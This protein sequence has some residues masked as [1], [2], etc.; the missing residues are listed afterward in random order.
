MELNLLKTD[1]FGR[2]FIYLDSVDST[3]SYLKRENNLPDGTVVM[4]NNQYAGRG[5]R[6]RTWVQKDSGS[7]AISLL[8]HNADIEDMGTLPLLCGLAAAKAMDGR[9]KWP[10]DVVIG[11]KKVCGVLCESLILG[12]KIN[13]VCGFGVNL[14][15]DRESFIKED[16]PYASSILAQT[17]KTFT[18]TEIC[19]LILNELE[20]LWKEYKLNGISD[21]IS[22]YSENCVTL[23]KTVKVTVDGKETVCKAVGVNNNGSLNCEYNDEIFSVHSGEASVRGL[24]GYI[25]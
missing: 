11:D 5:R 13:A 12:D 16:L 7:A 15:Q 8:I 1:V 2:N 17:G 24:Y 22:E 9:I 25:D 6:G 10:N 19:A 18:S 4:T 21:I 14:T 3:N 23:N 20:T